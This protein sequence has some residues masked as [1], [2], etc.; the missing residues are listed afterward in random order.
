[1]RIFLIVAA[2]LVGLANAT[3]Y[4]L[5]GNNTFDNLFE[6]NRDPWPLYVLYAFSAVFVGLLVSGGLVRFA[7][8]VLDQGFFARYGLLVMAVCIGGT[9]LAVFLTVVTFLFDAD[10]DT[11][12]RISE[13]SYTLALVAVP[14]AM[15]GAIEGVVLALP[16]S[17]LLGLFKK[18]NAET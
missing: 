1:M 16:L 7:E 3:L 15:L 4:S 13:T 18:P 12:K 6:W 5:I 10:A 11:P 14:G 9:V 17:W 8:E 2:I